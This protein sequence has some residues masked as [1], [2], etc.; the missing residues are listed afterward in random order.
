MRRGLLLALLVVG[1]SAMWVRWRG[2]VWHIAADYP[3][4]NEGP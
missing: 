1:A 2:E 3:V 4:G